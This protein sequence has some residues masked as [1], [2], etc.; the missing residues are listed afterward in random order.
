MNVKIKEEEKNYSTK[1]QAD[2]HDEVIANM[3]TNL[4][5]SSNKI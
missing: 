3:T 1:R 5:Y 2:G 4:G